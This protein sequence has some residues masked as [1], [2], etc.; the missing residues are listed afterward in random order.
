MR[1]SS[2]RPDAATFPEA[3]NLLAAHPGFPCQ[4]GGTASSDGSR[5]GLGL[6]LFAGGQE[7]DVVFSAQVRD[8]S[9]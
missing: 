2:R 5:L 8:V 3:P 4:V 6:Q 7:K 9:P 1:S